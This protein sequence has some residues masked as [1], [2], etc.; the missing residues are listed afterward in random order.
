MYELKIMHPVLDFVGYLQSC[1]KKMY[2]VFV[3]LSLQTYKAHRKLSEI[4][5]VSPSKIVCQK[6]SSYSLFDFYYKLIE[7][8]EVDKIVFLY[9]SPEEEST[10]LLKQLQTDLCSLAKQASDQTGV[11]SR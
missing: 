3:Q 5:R 6:F 9:I 4:F 11:T 7:T 1:D 2:L 8:K 10:S